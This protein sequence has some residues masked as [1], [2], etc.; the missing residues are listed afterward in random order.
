M[1]NSLVFFFDLCLY[2]LNLFRLFFLSSSFSFFFFSSLLFYFLDLLLLELIILNLHFLYFF[3]FEQPFSFLFQKNSSNY[4]VHMHAFPLC[5][6]LCSSISSSVVS[7]FSSCFLVS[8][9][10]FSFSFLCFLCL[11]PPFKTSIW[12]LLHFCFF[13][14]LVFFFFWKKKKQT[15]KQKKCLCTFAFLSFFLKKKSFLVKISRVFGH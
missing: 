12:K 6:L 4:P 2:L 11:W 9:T 3:F 15:N 13:F 5:V 7:F 8:I 1:L 14:L 10:C